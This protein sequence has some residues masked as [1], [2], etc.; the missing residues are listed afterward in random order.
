MPQTLN[1]PVTI[2]DPLPPQ[3]ISITDQSVYLPDT[4]AVSLGSFGIEQ[5]RRYVLD[6]RLHAESDIQ[7]LDLRLAL[8]SVNNAANWSGL[9]IAQAT[10]TQVFAQRAAVERLSASVDRSAQNLIRI[11]PATI[12]YANAEIHFC[13]QIDCFATGEIELQAAQGHGFAPL[14]SI[15]RLLATLTEVSSDGLVLPPPHIDT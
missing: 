5:G 6:I 8:E 14:T 9:G 11:D 15:Y 2:P 4:T 1:I 7:G 12:D 13:G 3:A 10:I